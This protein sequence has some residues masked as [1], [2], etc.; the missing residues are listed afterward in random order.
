MK[1]FILLI[2][3]LL[4]IGGCGQ[5]DVVNFNED[6]T[7]VIESLV[8]SADYEVTNEIKD[9]ETVQ[10]VIDILKGAKWQKNVE[11]NME[12]EPDLKLNKIYHIWISPQENILEIIDTNNK[13]YGSFSKTDSS[14]L[15][16]ILIGKELGSN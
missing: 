2:I 14:S 8:N 15:Y 11:V 5:K 13:N 9:K 16:K 7:L 10:K 1:K 6:S 12:S 4:F 3:L